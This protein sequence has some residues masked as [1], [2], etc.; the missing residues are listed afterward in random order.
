MIMRFNLPP[1]SNPA[2]ISRPVVWAVIISALSPHQVLGQVVDNFC[3]PIAP[4]S[5]MHTWPIF[6][7]GHYEVICPPEDVYRIGSPAVRTV[8]IQKTGITTSFVEPSRP[9]EIYCGGSATPYVERITTVTCM[10]LKRQARGAKPRLAYSS[11]RR[12]TIYRPLDGWS[13]R[14]FPIADGS[15]GPRKKCHPIP[16]ERE[17]YLARSGEYRIFKFS[18][19]EPPK[20]TNSFITRTRVVW[21]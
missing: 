5:D 21:C 13:A 17:R 14:P 11:V 15:F 2:R 10:E 16:A 20:Y 1:Q 12:D 7:Q 3:K 4:Q 9:T 6:Q 18:G 8:T 19:S